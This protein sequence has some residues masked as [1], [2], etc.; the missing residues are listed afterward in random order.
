M[1]NKSRS[2]KRIVRASQ[3]DMGGNLVY[4][5]LPLQQVEQIDP[6]LLIHH[7]DHPLPGNMSQ[8]DA[9]VGPHPHR[10]FSPVT[11][12]FKGDVEHRD[13]LG[14]QAVVSA[15]GTQWMHAGRGITHSER[16]SKEAAENGGDQ[17]FIQFWVNTPA[18]HKMEV[19]YYLPLSDKETPK[20][21]YENAT[22]GV[23]AGE[24]D[25]VVGPA[26]TYSPQLLLRGV[27]KEGAS[28]NIEIP[29]TFNTI[30]YVLDGKVRSGDHLAVDREMI[31]FENDGESAHLDVLVD[32]RFI[33]LAGEP[34]SE[35]VTSYGPFVMNNQTEILQ[36]LRDAQ[37]GKMGI[38][39]EEFE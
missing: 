35:E 25:G 39:I 32:S 19:P 4:Q 23:V 30:G 1:N 13:S 10:G 29:T 20:V 12:V 33:V 38:L 17:E 16:P 26:K 11:F 7:W 18:A 6:F 27:A 15:G 8:R 22:I 34:I 5:P 9:G 14:N 36:A 28:F 3:V 37:M 21:T 24:L 31:W 2:V